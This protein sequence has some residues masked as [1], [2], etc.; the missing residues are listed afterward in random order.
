MFFVLC[1]IFFFYVLCFMSNTRVHC[2]IS[3]VNV[4]SMP[5]KFGLAGIPG[6]RL[7]VCGGG[8]WWRFRP[9][10]TIA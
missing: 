5:T 8:G 6:T 1:F 9:C 4:L 3:N 7:K 2:F 10:N